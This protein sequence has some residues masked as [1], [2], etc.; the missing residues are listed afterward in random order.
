METRI[1]SLLKEVNEFVVADTP[2]P[3]ASGGMKDL[4]RR[5]KPDTFEDIVALVAYH[6]VTAGYRVSTA[7]TGTEAVAQARHD[8]IGP[9]Q[10]RVVAGQLR[11][12][13]DREAVDAA[14][15]IQRPGCK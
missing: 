7:S 2:L 4:I 3:K 10:H 6:L 12:G 5:L 14:P 15:E 9:G 11:A 1:Q 8:P 13:E